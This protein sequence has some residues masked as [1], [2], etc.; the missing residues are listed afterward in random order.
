MHYENLKNQLDIIVQDI[1]SIFKFS[2]GQ[3]VQYIQDSQF[4]DQGLKLRLYFTDT[5]NSLRMKV[6][7]ALGLEPNHKFEMIEV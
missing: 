7:K 4:E 3:F 1:S 6:V 2:E 5:V